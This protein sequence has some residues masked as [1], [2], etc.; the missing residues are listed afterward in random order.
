VLTYSA[1]T[2]EYVD[3][4]DFSN[5]R[6]LA[7]SPGVISSYFLAGTVDANGYIYFF[8]LAGSLTVVFALG[9]LDFF[10]LAFASNGDVLGAVRDDTTGPPVCKLLRWDGNDFSKSPM[11][12]AVPS[13]LGCARGLAVDK[14]TGNIVITGGST[15]YGTGANGYIAVLSPAADRVLK[16]VQLRH[17]A[18][19]VAVG[20]DG[21]IFMTDQITVHVYDSSVRYLGRYGGTLPRPTSVSVGADGAVYVAV[22]NDSSRA[23]CA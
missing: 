11:E 8:D 17:P 23:A 16:V 2:L 19:K 10:N 7:E 20:P 15:G 6:A 9:N 1:A 14:T 22:D 21:R 3:V 4:Y 5:V 18:G 12:V 13:P